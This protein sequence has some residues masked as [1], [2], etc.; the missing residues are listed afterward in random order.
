MRTRSFIAALALCLLP[1]AWLVV[2]AEQESASNSK[3]L[4]LRVLT[5]NIHHGEG[6]DGKLDLVRIAKVIAAVEPDLVALQEVDR[7][8]ARTGSIDQPAELA[9]LADMEVVFGPNLKLQGGEYGNA[10]LVRTGNSGLTIKSHKNHLLPSLD[11]GE[12]RGVLAVEFTLPGG[13][14]LTLL[15]THLD[16][17]RPDAER[18]A[19][20]AAISEL[21]AKSPDRPTILAGDLNATPDSAVL[22]QLLT[23]WSNTTDKPLPTIPVAQPERQIDY[24][25][26]RPAARWKVIE[27]KV[28][29]EPVASDHLPLLTVLELSPIE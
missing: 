2:F 24:I 13:G 12:Q 26:V 10:V 16:H 21:A 20:A 1:P 27:T 23:S 7:K 3:P 5:Y 25:L 18:L 19:S 17:R 9:K 14:E 4:C 22:K 28:L 29:D 6:V 8:V 15:A 11:G